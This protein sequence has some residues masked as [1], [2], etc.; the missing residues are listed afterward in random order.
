MLFIFLHEKYFDINTKCTPERMSQDADGN[1]HRCFRSQQLCAFAVR[2]DIGCGKMTSSVEHNTGISYF[3][4]GFTRLQSLHRESS[5]TCNVLVLEKMR[6]L[7][8]GWPRYSCHI[9]LS[10]PYKWCYSDFSYYSTHYVRDCL[11]CW[12]LRIP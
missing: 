4:S 6:V 8:V 10:A 12:R 11:T 5:L 3:I 7:C 9:H 2:Q 1:H